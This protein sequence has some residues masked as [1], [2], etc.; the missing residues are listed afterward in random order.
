MEVSASE[1]I[2]GRSVD[3]V[4]GKALGGSSKINATIYTRGLP[5]EYNSWGDIIHADDWKYDKLEEYFLKSECN[6]DE[7]PDHKIS[8][9]TGTLHIKTCGSFSL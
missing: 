2:G 6:L 8:G 9:S 1:H 3:L 4:G 5:A 7:Y